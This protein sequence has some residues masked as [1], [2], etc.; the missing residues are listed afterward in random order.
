MN[1]ALARP[2]GI[3]YF[4]F[5]PRTK[6][7]R[8]LLPGVAALGI[9]WL[10]LGGWMAAS[11]DSAWSYVYVAGGVVLLLRSVVG[12]VLVARHRRG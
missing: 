1:S 4:L 3:L 10:G 6:L 2:S 8:D 5:W 12:L 11:H 9:M 7:Y